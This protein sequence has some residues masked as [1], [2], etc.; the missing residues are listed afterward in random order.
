M[1][2]HQTSKLSFFKSAEIGFGGSLIPRI[3]G[4]ISSK[5]NCHSPQEK[6]KNI[7]SEFYTILL[8]NMLGN[9][10]LQP[11]PFHHFRFVQSKQTYISPPKY[12]ILF[13]CLSY[14]SYYVRYQLC[15][16]V[17]SKLEVISVNRWWTMG[18][19]F[20]GVL[21]DIYHAEDYNRY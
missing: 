10:F 7:S 17:H 8:K 2:R 3:M 20:S 1:S 9:L 21:R 14:E 15:A 4:Y 6:I 11:F 16:Y 13:T 19:G 18:V 5:F 12:K